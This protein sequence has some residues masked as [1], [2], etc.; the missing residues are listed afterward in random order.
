MSRWCCAA[1]SDKSTDGVIRRGSRGRIF[2]HPSRPVWLMW[3]SLSSWFKRS[4]CSTSVARWSRNITL[5]RTPI[6]CASEGSFGSAGLLMF[7]IFTANTDGENLFCPQPYDRAER[8]LQ[9]QTSVAEKGRS[10]G[11][12]EPYR[13]KDQRNGG[14]RANMIDRDLCRQRHPAASVPHRVA[15]GALNEEV[16]LA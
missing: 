1:N 13:L 5:K 2:S 8:L 12:F 10:F 9:A 4:R 14:R 7:L 11:C 3:P 6:T 16:T 15:F